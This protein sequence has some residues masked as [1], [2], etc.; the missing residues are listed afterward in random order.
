MDIFYPGSK[1]I[2]TYAGFFE[3]ELK[4]MIE[5]VFQLQ[6]LFFDFVLVISLN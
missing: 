2:T 1:V 4:S 5:K 3:E 6:K